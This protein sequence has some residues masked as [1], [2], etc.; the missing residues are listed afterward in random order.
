MA[1][2]EKYLKATE[3]M[4]WREKYLKATPEEQERMLAER[5]LRDAKEKEER[6][7]RI[8][9][10]RKKRFIDTANAQISVLKTLQRARKVTLEVIKQFDGKVLNNRLTKVVAQ[11]F[12]KIDPHLYAS[13]TIS[14]DSVLKNNA[15]VLEIEVWHQF[16]NVRDKYDI[17]IVLSSLVD[18][19]RVMF[20]ETESEKSNDEEYLTNRIQGYQDAIKG[21]D[22]SYKTAVRL[23]EMIE[24]YGKEINHH[25]REYFRGFNLISKTFY[26]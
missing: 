26:C 9:A 4:A 10:E 11:E 17:K 21:Y 2:R 23:N 8:Y 13:L 19:N 1:W 18:G 6:E 22:K 15:G 5:K 7:K 3:R 16:A 12:A 24:K 14:Y 25:L 20:A